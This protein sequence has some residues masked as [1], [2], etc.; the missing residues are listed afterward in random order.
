MFARW[1]LLVDSILFKSG[2]ESGVAIPARPTFKRRAQ[3]A[4]STD[5]AG[6]SDKT[7]IRWRRPRRAFVRLWGGFGLFGD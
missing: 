3:Q 5:G 1:E 7:R 2:S 6:E 4:A